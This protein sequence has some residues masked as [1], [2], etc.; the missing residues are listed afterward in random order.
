MLKNKKAVIFIF[1]AFSANANSLYELEKNKLD[2]ENTKVQLAS[3]IF[4][5]EKKISINQQA[6]TEKKME[7][8]QF[9]KTDRQL[10]SF[11]FGGLLAVQSRVQF[12][13]N[14]KIFEKIKNKNINSLRELK[15]YSEDL[16][17]QKKTFT[18]KQD[19]YQKT[20]A[21]LTAQIKKLAD[22]EK[23]AIEKMLL[24]N[25]N[26]LLVSKG[27]LA[28]PAEGLP[29]FLIEDNGA[30]QQ[31]GSITKGLTFKT[32]IGSN[33]RA[34]GRGKIIF[35]DHIKYWGESIIIEHAGDY[36]SVYTNLKN[37]SA[38]IN[39]EIHQGEKIGETAKDQFY[40]ELRNKNI[41][42]N[43]MK[44]IRN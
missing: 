18:E 5:T 6:I 11:E 32:K 27:H 20:D 28:S 30:G 1:I 42:L 44:W 22:A 13:N 37:C 14:I 38:E 31:F 41:A 15:Y 9:F 4:D 7:L 34:V 39:Q 2:I 23:Q 26:S 40:F 19:L 33:I 16:M 8:A 10:K 29:V 43:A 21:E 36:Y 25:E 12:E 17:S 3:E 35:R 24:T